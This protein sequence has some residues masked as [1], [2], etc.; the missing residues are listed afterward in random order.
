MGAIRS[1]PE[2]HVNTLSEDQAKFYF[3]TAS[4]CGWQHY[5]EDF[6]VSVTYGPA[7]LIAVIDGH[8]GPEVAKLCYHKL[9][10][11]LKKN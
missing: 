7:K 10:E 4:C 8:N 1:I 2:N 9:P 6:E 5:M 11:L 3:V